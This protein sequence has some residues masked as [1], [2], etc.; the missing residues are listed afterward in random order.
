M[1]GTFKIVGWCTVLVVSV[2]AGAGVAWA[3][4]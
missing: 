4:S 3:M 2:L 1:V